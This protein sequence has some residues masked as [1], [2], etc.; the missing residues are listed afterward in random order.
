MLDSKNFPKVCLLVSSI[1]SGGG[2]MTI[3]EC[4]KGQR[5]M[6]HKPTVCH[7]D[8]LSYMESAFFFLE[9]FGEK[10]EAITWHQASPQGEGKRSKPRVP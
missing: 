8:P 4:L 5:D 1:N 6:I 7:C 10:E 2:V 9:A 3:S